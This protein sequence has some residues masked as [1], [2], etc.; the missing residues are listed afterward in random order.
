MLKT[1]TSEFSVGKTASKS[2]DIAPEFAI[3]PD[4]VFYTIDDFTVTQDTLQAEQTDDDIDKS[5][6]TLK[7][8]W[9]KK[10]PNVIDN[11][12]DKVFRTIKDIPVT[13]QLNYLKEF[14]D[15]IV[16][17][18]TAPIARIS[19]KFNQGF[20]YDSVI[21]LNKYKDHYVLMIEAYKDDEF[22]GAFEYNFNKWLKKYEEIMKNK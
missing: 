6:K 18:N 4:R 19:I 8:V 13:T 2:V 14:K 3:K 16:N 9:G 10:L 1:K 15:S 12:S 11:I 21:I 22:I 17:S 20:R 7:D 5:V